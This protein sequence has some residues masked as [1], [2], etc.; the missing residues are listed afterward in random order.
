MTFFRH[1]FTTNTRLDM[2][3]EHETALSSNGP[4]LKGNRASAGPLIED[5]P[6]AI[7]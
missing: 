4:T 2:E 1:A 3:R 5:I 6:C 7:I